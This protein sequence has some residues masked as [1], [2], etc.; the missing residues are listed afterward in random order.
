VVNFAEFDA[1]L[2]QFDDA[3]QRAGFRGALDSLAIDARSGRLVGEAT[4]VHESEDDSYGVF[5]HSGEGYGGQV[6]I[7]GMGP[8]ARLDF[9]ACE[10]RASASSP[11]VLMEDSAIRGAVPN[12]I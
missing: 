9:K 7:P 12:S 10:G 6:V 3:S 1:L 11:P 5:L 8:A 2:F 4:Y